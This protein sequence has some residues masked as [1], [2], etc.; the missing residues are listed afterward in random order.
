LQRF[1][2]HERNLAFEKDF[3]TAGQMGYKLSR[4]QVGIFFTGNMYKIEKMTAQEKK[5]FQELHGTTPIGSDRTLD[6]L[7]KQKQMAESISKHPTNANI[8]FSPLTHYTY[9]QHAT[10]SDRQ[11]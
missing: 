4:K 6:P 10:D 11:D 5:E 7:M 8:E 2:E 1:G 9:E 3:L